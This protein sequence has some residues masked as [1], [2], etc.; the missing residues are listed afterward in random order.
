[1]L[2]HKHWQ[3]F[4]D[5]K[6]TEVLDC[7]CCCLDWMYCTQ[8]EYRSK[9]HSFC[10]GVLPCWHSLHK[11]TV[12][13]FSWCITS[14]WS[15]SYIWICVISHVHPVIWTLC[16]KFS[17][18]FFHTCHAYRHADFVHFI[19]SCTLS[20][21]DLCW[22]EGEGGHKVSTKQNVLASFYHL[23]FNW[24]GW[25]L[26]WWWNSFT[27]CY[28]FWTTF[29]ESRETTAA[30]LCSK[31]WPVGMHLD[32]YEPILFKCA[33]MIDS[34]ECYIS[35]LVSVVLTFIEGSRDAR[36]QKLLWQL[37]HKAMNR[38]L[39]NSACCWNLSVLWTSYSFYLVWSVVKGES[40]TCMILSENLEVG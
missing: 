5:N 37:S 15:M 35:I 19:Q 17:T 14:F 10:S 13:V 4:L 32:I 6:E 16:S 23:F 22:V 18:R 7:C 39:C 8:K 1:M 31:S 9:Y 28:Y 36:K 2:M 29:V 26:I 24:S 34:R 30:L 3:E 21:V 12:L 11:H 25:H 27:S 40:P 33:L 38:F 20:D